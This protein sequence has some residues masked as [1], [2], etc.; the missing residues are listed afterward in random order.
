[1]ARVGMDTQTGGMV[2]AQTSQLSIIYTQQLTANLTF[3]QCMYSTKILTIVVH[4][5]LFTQVQV[6]TYM[7]VVL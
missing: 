1:M 7:H 3:N 6:V 5:Y 2:G 4:I